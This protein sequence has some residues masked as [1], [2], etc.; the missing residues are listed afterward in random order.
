VVFTEILDYLL[1]VEV[2]KFRGPMG[3]HLSWK[4]VLEYEFAIREQAL[5]WAKR[6]QGTVKEMLRKA[7]NDT[8]LHTTHFITVLS[9]ENA[10]KGAQK[11]PPPAPSSYPAASSTDTWPEPPAKKGKGKGK[12][13]KQKAGGKKGGAKGGPGQNDST[14]ES[15]AVNKA[16]ATERLQTFV[17]GVGVCIR[18]N[19][20]RCDAVDCRFL[21]NCLRCGKPGHPLTSC[22]ASPT[23]L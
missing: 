9:L 16:K 5:E 17:D 22:R 15:R 2:I 7:M 20:G 18:Y 6:R 10:P 21:H 12:Q 8:K 3:Q 19:K 11:R 13:A 23:P 4:A 14:P 1:G